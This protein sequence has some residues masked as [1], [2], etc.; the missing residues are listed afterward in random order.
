M[1][2]M[3]TLAATSSAGLVGSG[4]PRSA[5]DS[6]TAATLI[7]FGSSRRERC[8]HAAKRNIGDE[9]SSVASGSDRCL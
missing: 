6:A 4:T 1:R 2:M 5:T 8:G 7:V 9:R 3:N